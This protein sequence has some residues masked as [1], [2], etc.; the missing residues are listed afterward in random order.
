MPRAWWQRLCVLPASWDVISWSV[1]PVWQ[2]GVEGTPGWDP[3][4]TSGFSLGAAYRGKEGA[5]PYPGDGKGICTDPAHA[6]N[7]ALAFLQPFLV[8]QAPRHP[9]MPPVNGRNWCEPSPSLVRTGAESLRDGREVT[10]SPPCQFSAQ[11]IS[12]VPTTTVPIPLCTWGHFCW[13]L[14]PASGSGDRQEFG[15]SMYLSGW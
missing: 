14:A 5:S 6:S 15:V 12:A 13:G 2:R 7:R 10:V 3:L 9:L 8:T 1:H 4:G 11:I